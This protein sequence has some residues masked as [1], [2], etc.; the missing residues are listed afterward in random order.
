LKQC[1]GIAFFRSPTEKGGFS[2]GT[3]FVVSVSDFLEE[4]G[5]GILPP[6]P[7]F[8]EMELT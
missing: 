1:G 5:T 7:M 4:V 6:A 8:L 3:R 2:H